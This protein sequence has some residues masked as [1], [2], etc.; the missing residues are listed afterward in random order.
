MEHA[1]EGGVQLCVD[2]EMESYG[3]QAAAASG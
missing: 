1:G 3:H 2:V